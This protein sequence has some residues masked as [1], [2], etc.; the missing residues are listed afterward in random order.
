MRTEAGGPSP[1]STSILEASALPRAA[2]AED[3]GQHTGSRAHSI[4]CGA[5]SG[6][7]A[8]TLLGLHPRRAEPEVG[9]SP[10]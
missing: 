7:P 6:P 8:G 3:L 1:H 10:W 5:P 2:R 9:R 4:G